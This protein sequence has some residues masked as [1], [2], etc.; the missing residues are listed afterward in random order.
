VFGN[1][2][3]TAFRNLK[4]YK[5]YSF[6]NLLGLSIGIACCI[7]I[8][9]YIQDEFRYD[10]YAQDYERIYRIV[11]DIRTPERG[12]MHIART[13]PPWGPSLVEDYPEV[14]DCVRFKTPLVSWLVSHEAEDTRFHEKGFYFADESVFEFF[15]LEL[16]KGDPETA[17]REP[18]TLV[19]TEKTAERYFK[20]QEPMGK[21]LRLDNAYDFLITGIMRAVPCN[22]HID[23]DLLAS[24]STLGA[25]PIYGNTEYLTWRAGLAP[26]LYTY[27]R[28]QEGASA[29]ELEAKL[30]EFLRNHIG[31]AL[32]RINLEWHPRLQPL[33]RIHLHSNLEAEIRANSDIRYVYVFSAI[34][35]FVL[36]IACINFMNL[37]TARSAGRAQEV[38]MRKVI[39]AEKGQ[40]VA[41]FIG[42]SMFLAFLA[43]ILAVLLVLVF[44]P[45]FNSLSGKDLAL[46][47]GNPTAV[48]GFL[49]VT[50]LV[51]LVSGSY[52]AFFL[53]SFQP[54][55]VFRGSLKAGRANIRLR[56]FLVVFQF[57]LSIVFII[58]TGVV[59]RQL[60]YVRNKVLGFDKEQVVVLPMGDPNARQIYRT[61]KDQVLQSPDVLA[62]SGS[63]SVPGGLINVLLML[64]EGAAQG[65][66]VT[67]EHYMV[68]HDFVKTMGIEMAAGRE[69]SLEYSTDEAEAFIL[70]ET[71]ARQLGWEDDA[72]DKRITIGNFKRG[73]VIGVVRDFHAKSLHQRIEP[74]LIH[75]AADPDPFLQLLVKISPRDY[76]AALQ[77]IREAW[78]QV[79]PND[80]FVY[81]F[82]DEDFDSLYHNE[83]QRG[84]IF[85][86]FSILAVLI[87]CLGLLGLASFTAEQKTKEIGI[88]KVLGASELSIVRLLSMEFI[89]LVFLAGLIAW[90]LAYLV[91]HNWLGNFA[92]RI[93][94]PFELFLLAGILAVL[95]ALGT[96]SFQ[97]VRA[98]LTNP[99]DSIRT[100]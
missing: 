61:F 1:Y 50:L 95:I 27:V 6:I 32:N 21:T 36:L 43:L 7:L 67:I 39:G 46:G 48:L 9:L 28:L 63:S 29:A 45:F 97:A 90:P 34:A 20:D 56:K 69:F 19:L 77:D 53:S 30:P 11:L 35:M 15:D 86:T 42:E 80:P 44:L 26:E 33:S 40:L 59:Y 74:L 85:L 51:G 98:S 88:R 17:L 5:G 87:A 92:Y 78:E 65:D 41:Q 84:Q 25:V 47:L 37:A 68:D 18:R 4:R 52:P 60:H 24:I 10:R 49:A 8:L 3:K 13:P 16:V 91:M 31:E 83:R 38:G 76:D 79:Y 22:S 55:A 81:S 70:N 100:E 93:A 64:P 89:R 62:V 82:L 2:I 96:V 58:G 94:M 66:E 73:R 23:F 99:V 72:L 71:G 14:E 57:S 12:D 75:I 54:V